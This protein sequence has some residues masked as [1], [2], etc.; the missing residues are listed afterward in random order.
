MTVIV[1]G[2]AV[3]TK[4]WALKG[5]EATLSSSVTVRVT[6]EP[7]VAVKEKVGA[8]TGVSATT[9]PVKVQS[10]VSVSSVPGSVT[11]EERV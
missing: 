5:A 8:L 3:P 10:Y 6:T 11:V 9:P 7:E 2:P 4:I 1:S